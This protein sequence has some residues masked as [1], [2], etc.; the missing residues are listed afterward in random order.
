MRAVL[1]PGQYVSSTD[2][3]SV[4]D[5]DREL[6]GLRNLCAHVIR[7]TVPCHQYHMATETAHLQVLVLVASG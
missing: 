6:S 7:S 3:R 5:C 4:C 2:S 1:I